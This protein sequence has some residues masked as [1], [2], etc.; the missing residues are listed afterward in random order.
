M[1][2]EMVP[3][4]LP[5]WAPLSPDIMVREALGVMRLVVE[6][7]LGLSWAEVWEDYDLRSIQDEL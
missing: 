1:G 4:Q 7:K 5:L 6:Q 3:V 2:N